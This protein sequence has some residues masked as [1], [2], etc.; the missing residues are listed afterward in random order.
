MTHPERYEIGRSYV[1]PVADTVV[2]GVAGL[3]PLFG[4]RHDDAAHL[5]FPRPH[6]HI[7]WRLVRKK[8]YEEVVDAFVGRWINGRSLVFAHVIYADL[9][10]QIEP[11]R[12]KCLRDFAPYP[13]LPTSSKRKEFA[14]LEAAYANHRLGPRMI[15]PHKGADLSSVAPVDGC[16]TCPLHGL[17]WNLKTGECVRRYGEARR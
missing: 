16:V 13:V 8:T 5:D 2:A 15:C 4:P 17:T 12:M 14:A 1:V 6:W 9:T 11:R 10:I 3:F 7:D